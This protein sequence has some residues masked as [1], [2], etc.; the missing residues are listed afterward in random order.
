MRPALLLVT[1]AAALGLLS[2]GC[3]QRSE[4]TG[5][6]AQPYPVTVQGAGDH[7]VAL[8][9]LPERIVALDPGSA[10]LL[11][12]LGAGERLVGVPA[13]VRLAD[14]RKAAHVVKPNGQID[15]D[16]VDRLEPDLIVVAADTDP[17]DVAQAE[18]RTSA[19]VYVQPSRTVEDVE[20]AVIEI[21]FLIGQPVEARQLAGSIQRS[22]AETD[23]RL[24]A[25]E[26]VST[27]V[28]RGFFITVSNRSLLGNLVQRAHGTNIAGDYAGLGPFPLARLRKADPDVYLATSDSDVTRASLERDPRTRKLRA[29]AD[30]RVV[31]LPT[32]LVT[33]AGPRIANALE[34]VAAALHPDAF[35]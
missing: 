33:R 11:D 18:R 8:E 23:A 22:L 19:A 6:L 30:G 28:D 35:R 34:T 5:E 16:R 17:V 1:V 27:F 29:V 3:G 15:V 26:P 31:V 24:A 7:P 2:A 4:P 10:E 12:A 25:V 32:D 21:G 20:R 13:G 14:K 9:G